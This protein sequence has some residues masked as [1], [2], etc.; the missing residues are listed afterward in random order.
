MKLLSLSLQNSV[1]R[2]HRDTHRIIE[3]PRYILHASM[4]MGASKAE[5]IQVKL[6]AYN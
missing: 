5:R 6:S 4:H 2:T 3:Q 1:E